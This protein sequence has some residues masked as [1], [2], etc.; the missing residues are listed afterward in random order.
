MKIPR[1]KFSVA[2]P[3]PH[4]YTEFPL[5]VGTSHSQMGHPACQH[6]HSATLT[7]FYRLRMLW[8]VKILWWP[9]ALRDRC[10]QNSRFLRLLQN[11]V[12]VS[13]MTCAFWRRSPR[14]ALLSPP[15][16]SAWPD[17]SAHWPCSWSGGPSVQNSTSTCSLSP[18]ASRWRTGARVSHALD[19]SCAVNHPELMNVLKFSLVPA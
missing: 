12:T 1:V 8:Q 5:L 10:I 3:T 15:K 2:S 13:V 16:T 17:S 7:T 9:R 11:G 6:L 4:P 19:S 18:M 14:T